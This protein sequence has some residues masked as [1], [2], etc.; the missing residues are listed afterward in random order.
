M[1]F[2]TDVKE[3]LSEQFGNKRHCLIAEAAAIFTA[4]GQIDKEED[5][6]YAAIMQTDNEAVAR[7]YYT[8]IKKAFEVRPD[9]GLRKIPGQKRRGTYVLTVS[10]EAGVRM[11]EAF[12]ILKEDGQICCDGGVCNPSLYQR[13]CCKRAFLRGAFLASGSIS[14]PEKAYHYELVCQT[15]ERAEQLKELML[16]FDIEA[17]MVKRKNHFVVYVKEG[18]QLVDLLNVMEAHGALMELENVRIIREISGT[19]NRKV[20]C[21][22]AN[23]NKTVSAA[24]QQINDI[25]LL[26]DRLGFDQLPEGLVEIAEARLAKPEASLKELGDSLDPPVGKSGVNH[27]LRKIKEIAN[28][29]RE[30]E[31]EKHDS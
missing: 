15:K 30:D 17:G 31:E 10:G 22:T 4:C 18:S 23:I 9:A 1:S 27:R 16:E 5:G 28:G 3:E 21:E 29:L 13:P 8:L 2:S 6:S 24:V 25:I 14:N 20:N 7:K 19:V 26:R 12:Y 11:L